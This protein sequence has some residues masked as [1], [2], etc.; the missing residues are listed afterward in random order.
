MKQV[1]TIQGD[2]CIGAIMVDDTMQIS[3]D[4]RQLSGPATMQTTDI[5]T[6]DT[7]NEQN[8]IATIDAPDGCIFLIDDK[9]EP[10]FTRVKGKWTAPPVP[11]RSRVT[12]DEFLDSLTDKQLDHLLGSTDRKIK[13]FLLRAPTGGVDFK[14]A[15]TVEVMSLIQ[16]GTHARKS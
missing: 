14:D 12:F 7:I 3:Q 1:C 6:G 8:Y 13:M 9:V 5:I 10:G 4:R 16:A 2:C 11:P 15:R